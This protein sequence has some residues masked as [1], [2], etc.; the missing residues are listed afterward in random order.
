MNVP[1]PGVG[2]DIITAGG[3]PI[4]YSP[5]VDLPKPRPAYFQFT[6]TGI[7]AKPIARPYYQ[8]VSGGDTGAAPG[9]FGTGGYGSSMGPGPGGPYGS[10]GAGPAGS[11]GPYSSGP[12]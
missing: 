3:A 1:T 8:G 6:V 11:G 2:T 10:G 9:G 12:K 7:L 4:P 5:A